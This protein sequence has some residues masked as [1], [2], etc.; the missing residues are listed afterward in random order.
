[1]LVLNKPPA[2]PGC[3]LARLLRENEPQQVVD[4]QLAR[5]AQDDAALHGALR[6][7]APPAGGHR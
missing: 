5:V 7:P 1:M 3:C 4:D 6:R 2:W